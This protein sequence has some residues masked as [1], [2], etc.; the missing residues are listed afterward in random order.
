MMVFGDDDVEFERFSRY[1]MLFID[2]A[3]VHQKKFM[4]KY[5][6]EGIKNIF[7]AIGLEIGRASCRERV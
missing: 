2:I 6:K 4:D 3:I 1:I 7:Y 5:K